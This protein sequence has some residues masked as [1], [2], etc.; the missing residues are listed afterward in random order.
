MNIS[1]KWLSQYMDVSD[2]SME[3]I[4]KRITDAGLEVEGISYMSQG[5]NLVIGQVLTCVDHPDSDHLHICEVDVQT[6]TLQIVCGASNVAAG[7]KVIVA[8]VGA[9]L[10]EIEIKA[11]TIRGCESNGMI[12]S[13]LE[14]GVDSQLLNEESKN[15]IEVLP[16]DAPIGHCDTVERCVMMMSY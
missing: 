3:E 6:E 9:K 8:K 1:K 12:C 10:P 7:Q 13:L 14:L 4:A 5:T 11:G 16:S 15:G 2:I